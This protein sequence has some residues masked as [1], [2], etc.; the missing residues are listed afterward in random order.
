MIYLHRIAEK[1]AGWLALVRSLTRVVPLSD[2]LGPAVINL[3]LDECP[4]PTK[5]TLLCLNNCDFSYF[6]I[7][8]LMFQESLELLSFE[9]RLSR[10]ESRATRSNVLHHRNSCVVLGCLAEKMAGS[11]LPPFQ[12]VT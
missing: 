11:F 12:T 8:R 10:E 6:L 7:F 4:L 1:D 2:P 3:L 5:V 9:L